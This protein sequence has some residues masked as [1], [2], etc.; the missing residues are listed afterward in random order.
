MGTPATSPANPASSEPGRPFE[1]VTHP[2]PDP[3]LEIDAFFVGL[4]ARDRRFAEDTAERAGEHKAFVD[5]FRAS[6]QWEVRPAMEA[7]LDR[8][9]RNGGGGLIEE[10]AS[11]QARPNPRLTLW[12][13][14]DGDIVGSPRPDR[15]PYF[16]VDA[17][18][19]GREIQISEG[20]RYPG[21]GGSRSGRAAVWK[22]AELKRDRI[23]TEIVGIL[24]RAVPS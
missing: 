14:L 7:V 23:T 6:C 19:D 3:L 16:Q 5:G 11:T 21:G 12:M 24:R 17:N 8:L 22:L 20:D 18:I 15:H 9:H 2:E 10:H 4:A 13:S 1:A